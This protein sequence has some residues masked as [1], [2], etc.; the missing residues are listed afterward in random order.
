VSTVLFFTQKNLFSIT[1]IV[2]GLS[3]HHY[4]L[5]QSSFLV[6]ITHKIFTLPFI[7]I[8]TQ[9]CHNFTNLFSITWCLSFL[10]AFTSVGLSLLHSS[11]VVSIGFYQHH[12]AWMSF[13][14]PKRV[15][16]CHSFSYLTFCSVILIF[17][18]VTVLYT[19]SRHSADLVF[20]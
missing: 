1:Y 10:P 16:F 19:T 17:G 5:L 11:C 13:I 14:F 4:L 2:E 8:F 15:H 18:I 3:Y 6:V 9:Y 12:F 7:I 20:C